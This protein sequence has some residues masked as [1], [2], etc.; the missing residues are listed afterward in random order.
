VQL[1][2]KVAVSHMTQDGFNIDA[3]TDPA[4]HLGHLWIASRLEQHV[5][6]LMAR[7]LDVCLAVLS[8]DGTRP[9]LVRVRGDVD[10]AAGIAGARRAYRPLSATLECQQQST[11]GT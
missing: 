9:R 11:I 6:L 5:E 4:D 10:A 2:K 8:F 7:R 1:E 3:S